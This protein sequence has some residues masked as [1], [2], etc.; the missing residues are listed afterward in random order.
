MITTDTAARATETVAKSGT[1]RLRVGHGLAL[2]SARNDWGLY[3]SEGREGTAE[4]ALF[5]EP[6]HFYVAP[7]QTLYFTWTQSAPFGRP[8]V[9]DMMGGIKFA[10]DKN[11]PPRGTYIGPL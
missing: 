8:S 5:A 11:Y 7:D 4:A 6:G 2:S 1:A 10:L 9:S 3:I